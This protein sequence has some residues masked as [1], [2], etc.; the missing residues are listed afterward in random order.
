M[1]QLQTAL[2]RT[3]LN[4]LPMIKADLKSRKLPKSARDLYVFLW[5]S[6]HSRK[7]TG[8]RLCP[9]GLIFKI[10]TL[11]EKLECSE[12]TIQRN[13][14]QLEAEGIL[15]VK[16]NTPPKRGGSPTHRLVLSWAPLSEQ[17]APP[18]KIVHD[19]PPNTSIE[20]SED[21][22]FRMEPEAVFTWPVSPCTPTDCHPEDKPQSPVGPTVE[23]PPSD[24]NID[25][26][27][28]SM[29]D[30]PI[31]GAPIYR[32]P[33]ESAAL[34]FFISH[35]QTMGISPAKTRLWS[36]SFGLPRLAQVV[37][38]VLAAPPQTIVNP[39]G[40]IRKALEE[41]WTSPAYVKQARTR[42]R[43][44]VTQEARQRVAREQEKAALLYS[45][46]INARNARIWALISP[47]L[48]DL[49]EL[50][51]VAEEKARN[52]STNAAG[53]FVPSVFALNFRQGS[54]S[55]R[56]FWVSAALE[57][58]ELWSSNAADIA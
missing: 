13:I 33:S 26:K 55:W 20:P 30:Q 12:R 15:R 16:K 49:V 25:K 34:L 44:R 17:S 7:P 22:Q 9:K 39:G 37:S 29:S 45:E 19:V 14:R 31:P 6:N 50:G 46:S 8:E 52:A 54:A 48:Q 41:Q 1:Q 3:S 57:Y 2:A 43:V 53:H 4:M 47:R 36:G 24:A 40:W 32:F 5:R 27:T 28:Y 58:P 10:K 23:V 56:T 18:E 38:W 51:Q 11:A 21:P 35:L 42:C